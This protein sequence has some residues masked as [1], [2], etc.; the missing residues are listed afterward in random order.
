[1]RNVDNEH[2]FVGAGSV[3]AG[4]YD[5][6]SAHSGGEDILHANAVVCGRLANYL[7]QDALAPCRM[8]TC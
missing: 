6:V 8:C 4:V 3:D 2:E 5:I 7:F 1:M